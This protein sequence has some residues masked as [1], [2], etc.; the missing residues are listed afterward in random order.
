MRKRVCALTQLRFCVV[1]EGPID[2]I[3]SSLFVFG[4]CANEL[5]LSEQIGVHLHR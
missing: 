1:N 2:L 4:S 3:G 5:S